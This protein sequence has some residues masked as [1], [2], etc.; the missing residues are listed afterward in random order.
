MQLQINETS[1]KKVKPDLI[2]IHITI[3]KYNIN[4]S[5][6]IE[7]STSIFNLLKE[8]LFKIKI[9]KNSI[10]SE[11][12]SIRPKF[13]SNNG[14]D[15]DKSKIK[16]YELNHQVN[17]SIKND[18]K[19]LFDIFNILTNLNI[20]SFYIS[21]SLKDDSKYK[22]DCLNDVINQCKKKAIDIANNMN[23][24]VEDIIS[25]D[26]LDNF[27]S[28]LNVDSSQ[29]RVLMCSL[30]NNSNTDYN[31]KEIEVSSSVQM[32]FLLK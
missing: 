31:F 1:K 30:D 18:N 22:N 19:L 17:V 6:L 28:Y 2:T 3:N 9:K 25:L 23:M 14:Y 29:A 8:E 4:Y 7:E 27:V 5:S 16:G 20:S 13:E 15:I 26:V 11:N 24:K 12:I 10:K 21:Y 32:K